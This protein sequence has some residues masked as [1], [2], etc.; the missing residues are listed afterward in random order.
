MRLLAVRAVPAMVLLL[1]TASCAGENRVAAARREKEAGLRERFA[2][3]GLRYPAAR[4]YLRAFKRERVL[5]MWA[6]P[7][8][9]PL[10]LVRTYAIVAASGEL[11]PK[12]V[13]GDLQV[14]EGFYVVERFNPQSRFHLSLGLDYP[15][16][17]DRVRSDRRRPGG[18]IFIHG[19][20]SSIGCMALTDPVI[21]EVYVC[22]AD[23]ARPIDVHVFPCR[24]T[25]EA[26]KGLAKQHG[27][28]SDLLRFWNEIRPGYTL[29]ERARKVPQVTV[30]KDGTYVVRP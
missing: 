12:R 1:A 22:A 4:L 13:E 19:G 26:M 6:G 23:A 8:E 27:A 18:D 14:P 5:E 17:S 7:R 2:G 25:D 21:R 11:G 16:A 30:R 10:K 28:D 3:L 24:M 15:N 29:F 9:G 20:S